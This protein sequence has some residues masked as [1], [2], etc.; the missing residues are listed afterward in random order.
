MLMQRVNAICAK[1]SDQPGTDIAKLRAA[2]ERKKSLIDFR[3][4]DIADAKRE[5]GMDSVH[6]QKLDGLVDGWREVEKATN[7]ELAGLG[8]GTTGAG[9]GPSRVR[10]A[11]QA[12]G[13]RPE[14]EQLRSA[15]PRRRPDDRAHQAGVRVGPHARRRVH[16][17]RRVERSPLADPRR[18][19]GPPHARAQQRRRRAEH[20]G[21]VLLRKVRRSS[22]P[23]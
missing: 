3:L 23:R 19:Q 11:R 10:P 21:Q 15:V 7:A 14:Q 18:R 13:Q 17:V 8:T 2:L 5:L 20:H 16:L 9:P 4:A 6:A 12:D 22:W 1:D